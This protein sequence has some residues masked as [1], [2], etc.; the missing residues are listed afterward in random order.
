MINAAGNITSGGGTSYA[1]PL[2]A[3]LAAGLWQKNPEWT[4]TELRD[5]LITTASRAE[6]PS[7]EY[8]YGIPSFGAANGSSLL[9]IDEIIQ[10]DFV[11]Y[12]N[13]LVGNELFMKFNNHQQL[14]NL[15]LVVQ[16]LQG[17]EWAHEE[18]TGSLQEYSISLPRIAVGTYILTIS[19]ADF[20]RTVKIIKK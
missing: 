11:V 13:P 16:D 7:I 10:S 15:T 2:V 5:V 8:G 3:G 4:N 14:S 1:S 20:E 6:N 19:N 18:I 9:D 12:P 17:R